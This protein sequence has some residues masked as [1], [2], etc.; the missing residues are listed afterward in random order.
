MT[1]RVNDFSE[2]SCMIRRNLLL[3]LG[4]A[5]VNI[6]IASIELTLVKD[7]YPKRKSLLSDAVKELGLARG[8][9]S[10]IRSRAVTDRTNGSSVLETALDTKK[11]DELEAL[12]CRWLGQAQWHQGKRQEAVRTF[13]VAQGLFDDGTNSQGTPEPDLVQML[14]LVG[15]ESY[16]SSTTLAQLA[17]EAAGRLQVLS[18]KHERYS[19]FTNKGEELVGI[20]CG[21]YRRAASMVASLEEL[22]GQSTSVLSFVDIQEEY[23]IGSKNDVQAAAEELRS[24][25][26]ERKAGIDETSSSGPQTYVTGA[27]RPRSDLFASGSS[28]PG[29]D[30]TRRFTVGQGRRRRQ[31]GDRGFASARIASTAQALASDNDNIMS[32]NP[33]RYRK[34]GDELLP[35]VT[36]DAGGTI[37]KIVYPACAPERPTR[38][39]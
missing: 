31:T 28:L 32:E 6:G 13:D 12:A 33:V 7:G 9:A 37:P 14:A 1:Q 15:V 4:R 24:W 5:H 23:S 22:C 21:A 26:D 27:D 35:Q 10:A 19:E 8:R 18:R 39:L 20:A 38:G 16:F 17:S 11:A 34:W 30:P 29:A 36:T 25:W 2:E 3:L